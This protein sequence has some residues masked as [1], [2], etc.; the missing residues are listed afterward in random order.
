MQS[1]PVTEN[2]RL[3]YRTNSNLTLHINSR[4]TEEIVKGHEDEEQKAPITATE[5]LKVDLEKA[6][7]GMILKNILKT[8][9]QTFAF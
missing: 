1:D 5:A 9:P 2:C 3:V 7:S 6:G 4:I 8:Y